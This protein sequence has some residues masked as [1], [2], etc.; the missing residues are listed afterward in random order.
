MQTGSGVHPVDSRAWCWPL[1]S[2]QLRGQEWVDLYY[3]PSRQRHG[4]LYLYSSRKHYTVKSLPFALRLLLALWNY[5]HI[6]SPSFNDL[7]CPQTACSILPRKCV[8]HSNGVCT[9]PDIHISIRNYSECLPFFWQVAL[10]Q[11]AIGARRFEATT[12]L[13][14][15]GHQSPSKEAFH[16]TRTETSTAPLRK[17]KM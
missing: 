16:S 1:T 9:K 15:V 8:W 14:N 10:Y 11:W 4:H 17:P 3:I 12:L 13:R 2:I 6:N 7:D 5:H